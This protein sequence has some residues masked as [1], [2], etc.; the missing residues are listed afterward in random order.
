[1]L[2]TVLAFQC[3]GLQGSRLFDRV[4]FNFPHAESQDVKKQQRMLYVHRPG[5]ARVGF[6]FG[7]SVIRR[8]EQGTE[9]FMTDIC[10]REQSSPR[11]GVVCFSSARPGLLSFQSVAKKTF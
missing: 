9:L 5:F 10:G 1:M 4:I 6:G 8:K 11:W 3:I 7:L 2:T